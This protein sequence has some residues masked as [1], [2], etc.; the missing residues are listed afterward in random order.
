MYVRHPD[1][2]LVGV[3]TVAENA[4][5]TESVTMYPNACHLATHMPSAESFAT[6]NGSDYLVAEYKNLICLWC[7]GSESAGSEF[8]VHASCRP[9]SL[10]W[11]VIGTR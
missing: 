5:Q 7:A 1:R 8:T 6:Q 11:S 10:R 3:R 4:K 2:H 9:E